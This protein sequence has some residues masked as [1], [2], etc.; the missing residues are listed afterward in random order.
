[1]GGNGGSAGLGGGAGAS[2]GQSGGGSGGRAGGG[3]G[4]NGGSGGTSGRGG[5]AGSAGSGGSGGAATYNPCPAAPAPCVILPFG[6][7]ITDG[8]GTPGGYRIDLFRRTLTDGKR[9]TFVGSRKTAR[10][11][12]TA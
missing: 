3:S 9:I 5:A 8:F 10:P 2:G 12:S 6:D 4:G 11:W 7:S 1:M